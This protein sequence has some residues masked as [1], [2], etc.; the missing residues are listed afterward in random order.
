MIGRRCLLF[1]RAHKHFVHRWRFPLPSG[2]TLHSRSASTERTVDHR[3]SVVAGTH[4]RNAVDDATTKTASCLTSPSMSGY[5]SASLTASR[6]STAS[7]YGHIPP[8]IALPMP[9]PAVTA[10]C[11]PTATAVSPAVAPATAAAAAS[12]KVQW[13]ETP[14]AAVALSD[15]AA[16][17]LRRPHSEQDVILRGFLNDVR[18]VLSAVGVADCFSTSDLPPPS[19]LATH[20]YTLACVRH[21]RL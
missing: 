7:G 16:A 9:A 13:T 21:C 19:F 2:S 6:P 4:P 3:T 12:V 17:F 8:M 20:A 10:V 5:G 11:T 1:H 15:R 18:T 14:K